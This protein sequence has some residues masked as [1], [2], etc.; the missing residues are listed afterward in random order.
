[1]YLII[2]S[3]YILTAVCRSSLYYFAILTSSGCMK[4]QQFCG[5][6]HSTLQLEMSPQSKMLKYCQI[7]EW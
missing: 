6:K 7:F 4:K 2:K 1:M 5:F 3:F